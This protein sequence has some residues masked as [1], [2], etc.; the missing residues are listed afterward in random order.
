MTTQPLRALALA[1]GL[2]GLVVLLSEAPAQDK[3]PKKDATP[4]MAAAI[5]MPIDAT[6]ERRIV[7]VNALIEEERWADAVADL[8]RLVDA[9]EGGF[10][11]VDRMNAGRKASVTVDARA[12]TLRL[13]DS[14]PA[15]AIEEYRKLHGPAARD[16]L[17]DAREKMDPAAYVA[18]ASRYALTEA[19][20]EALTHLAAVAAERGDFVESALWFRRL[21]A[22]AA[23]QQATAQT[24]FRAALVFRQANDPSGTEQ[25]WKLLVAKVAKDGLMVDGRL[26]MLDDLQKELDKAAPPLAKDWP[27]HRGDPARRAQGGGGAPDLTPSWQVSTLPERDT[28]AW[29]AD[30]IKQGSDSLTRKGLPVLPAFY[31]VA[32][33]GRLLFRTYNGLHVVNLREPLKGD[34]RHA[35]AYTDCGAEALLAD[36]NRKALLDQWRQQFA[37]AGP[38]SLIFEN[39]VTGT[40]TTDGTRVFLVDDLILPPFFD[41]TGF[42]GKPGFGQLADRADRNT[43]TA[44]SAESTKL[45]FALGGK[46]KTGKPDLD[47]LQGSFFLS[48]PL[49]LSGKLYVLNEKNNELRLL[50]LQPNGKPDDKTPLPPELLWAQK[51]V[52]TR[53]DIVSDLS[54]RIHAA[55]L[56]YGEGILVCPT[57][58]GAIIGID[59]ATR[60]VAWVHAYREPAKPNPL[61]RPGFGPAGRPLASSALLNEWKDA[62]PVIVDGKVLFTSWDSKALH[63]LHLREGTLLWREARTAEDVYL[64]GVVDG[65]AIVVG[66]NQVRALQLTDGKEVWNI[67]NTGLPTGQGVASDNVYYLP[68]KKTDKDPEIVAIDITRGAIQASIPSRAK[69]ASGQVQEVGNLMFHEGQ[70]ISQTLDAVI[71]Y[72]LAARKAQDKPR[73]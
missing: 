25:A 64:A 38:P 72:P 9:K 7:R 61:E 2:G 34:A 28:G 6:L 3:E 42:G 57:N 66:K 26:R 8:Q 33:G 14:L 68:V 27:V 15:K 71:G 19:G 45:L 43:L 63:C 18:V 52:T 70:L 44:Y 12:E 36:P 11:R 17:K 16:L 49:V 50:C 30:Q 39:S 54:R 22:Q 21:L 10:V 56:A 23:R 69:K 40:A 4:T 48:A 51:L 53:D 5:A 46:Q 37:Q 20:G 65:K 31:P 1:F 59:L 55:H 41:R 35:W 67:A 60:G 73:E 58:A 13:L 32:A 29:V 24:L 62:P 47:D